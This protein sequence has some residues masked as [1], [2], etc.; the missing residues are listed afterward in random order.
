MKL[1]VYDAVIVGA[2]I[3]ITA[4]LFNQLYIT[5]K[6]KDFEVVHLV[7][8]L[9]AIVGLTFSITFNQMIEFDLVYSYRKK[10]IPNKEAYPLL[11]IAN[12][13]GRYLMIYK[14]ASDYAE[15]FDSF[16]YLQSDDGK[17][18]T[19]NSRNFKAAVITAD[20][21]SVIFETRQVEHQYKVDNGPLANILGLDFSTD[22]E[23]VRNSEEG[24]RVP[25]TWKKDPLK[26][27]TDKV[28]NYDKQIR[29]D[30]PEDS[31]LTR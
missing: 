21:K 25:G 15:G 23:T 18:I 2:P 7:I 16:N 20:N 13:N 1:F 17:P 8:T 26:T 29:I 11:P 31:I 28:I 14:Y 19:S 24:G 5:E 12:G 6:I 9:V 30:V 27:D 10:V 3:F 4:Y 22:W